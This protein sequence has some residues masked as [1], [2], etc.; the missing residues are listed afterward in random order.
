MSMTQYPTMMTNILIESCGSN[1]SNDRVE[2]PARQVRTQLACR[3]WRLRSIALFA[4][5]FRLGLSCGQPS[6]L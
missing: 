3:G 2:T 5:L 4:F 6:V 1:V